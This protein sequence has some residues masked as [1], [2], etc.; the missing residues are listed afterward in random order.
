MSGGV[1]RKV[2]IVV[3]M[4]KDPSLILIDA[5]SKGIDP[6]VGRD[7]LEALH[8]LIKKRE[9]SLLFTTNREK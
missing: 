6:M 1:R 5:I 7:I 3:A 2:C 8:Q 9:I 4:M